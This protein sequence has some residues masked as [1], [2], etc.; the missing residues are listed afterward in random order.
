MGET[1]WIG[2]GSDVNDMDSIKG[3]LGNPDAKFQT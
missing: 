1:S 3:I 2:S